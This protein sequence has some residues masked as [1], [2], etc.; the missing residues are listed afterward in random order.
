M[1][2]ATVAETKTRL[3]SLIADVAAGEDVLITRRRQS[4]AR[5]I[6]EP[7][8]PASAGRHCAP[9]WLQRPARG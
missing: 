5:L 9:G 2:V 1:K 3:S 8:R 6:A 7:G 4:V